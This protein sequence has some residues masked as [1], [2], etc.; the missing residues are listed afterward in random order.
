MEFQGWKMVNSRAKGARAELKIRDDLRA[1][2]GH[3]WERVP[4]SGGLS[5]VHQLKGDLYIPGE[6]GLYCVEVKHYADDH[7]TSK[8]I[9]D[10]KPQLDIWWEQTIR[11]SHQINKKPILIFK[12]DRGKNFCGV[13]DLLIPQ[14]TLPVRYMFIGHLGIWVLKLEDFIKH[15]KPVFIK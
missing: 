3:K 2:T 10:T 1:L 11:E 15:C 5:A 14:N 9:T 6:V 12:H 13:D 8:V 7:L 4:A